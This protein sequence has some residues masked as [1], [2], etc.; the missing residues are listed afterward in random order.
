MHARAHARARKKKAEEQK[1]GLERRRRSLLLRAGEARRAVELAART[2]ARRAAACVFAPERQ[3]LSKI[4]KLGHAGAGPV[5]AP[6]VRP[7]LLV[8]IAGNKMHVGRQGV[9]RAV[10]VLA[11]ARVYEK[12]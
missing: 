4:I 6:L 8:R 7:E 5:L 10:S 11:D 9:G 3:A 12:K 2:V 1:I